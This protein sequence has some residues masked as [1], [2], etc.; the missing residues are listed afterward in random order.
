M[1][2]ASGGGTGYDPITS[3]FS[4]GKVQPYAAHAYA[5]VTGGAGKFNDY[6]TTAPFPNT[7]VLNQKPTMQVA[8]QPYHT[9]GQHNSVDNGTNPTP[10]ANTFVAVG[11]MSP[12]IPGA[13]PTAP[14]PPTASL[15]NT[16]MTPFDWMVH[17][18]RP[19]VNP[20]ELFQ[21][22]DTAP[23]RVTD[24]FI[25]PSLVTTSGNAPPGV[26]Y[27]AGY[28]NWRDTT[29]GMT[30]AL[31]YLAV[32]PFTSG[33]PHG[34]RVPG[35]INL[36]AIQDQRVF[37]GLLD[38]PL[39]GTTLPTGVLPGNGFD[40]TFFGATVS[41]S[42]VFGPAA[43]WLGSRTP[44]GMT[45]PLEQPP[46][47]DGTTPIYRSWRAGSTVYE[48]YT[49]GTDRPFTSLGAPT[50]VPPAMSAFQLYGTAATCGPTDQW[51]MLR[52]DPSTNSAN[53]P[54]TQPT[55]YLYTNTN[56]RSVGSATMYPAYPASQTAYVQGGAPDGPSYYQAEIVRKMLNNSTTVN[57]QYLVFLTI[58]YFEVVGSVTVSN[59]NGSPVT[60]PQLG[61]EAYVNAPGD[62]RQQ[63]VAV[64]D[65]SN[66]ALQPT[67]N[68]LTTQQPFFTSL[69]QTARPTGMNGTA[70]LTL[71]YAQHTD[72][73][74]VYVA[75][76][77]ALVPISTTAP[78]NTLVLGYGTEQQVVTVTSVGD[79]TMGGAGQ[80][81]VTGMTRT[82][83]AG[84]CVSNVRPGY[85]GP[86]PGFQYDNTSTYGYV[87]PYIQRLR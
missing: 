30:R 64:V 66:M 25:I 41:G 77:G 29:S 9:F 6:T 59:V 86:Q 21:V 45:T 67:S 2:R 80:V 79:P 14:M 10:P 49:N 72:T 52:I 71:A 76:D 31:E 16:L 37:Q 5:T 39:A 13:T 68:A 57:Q 28:A 24:L 36:N 51:S 15:T 34:G 69:E 42:Y 26:S 55:P 23:H 62:A 19:L 78:Y 85:P 4:V 38:P 35:R 70:T 12:A 84:S 65:M 7:F 54:W 11:S 27:N 73:S 17:P 58:G 18:D 47:A 50:T 75:A 74:A 48:D 3:R 22:R 32:K 83:W 43:N 60:I 56:N 63:F 40:S 33:V 81:S 1:A 20:F 61:A 46:L 44:G 87:L 8:N 82:A 53:N